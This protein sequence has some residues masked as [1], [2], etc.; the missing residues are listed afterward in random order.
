MIQLQLLFCFIV[1]REQLT[2]K[3]NGGLTQI[4]LIVTWCIYYEKI[5]YYELVTGMEKDIHASHKG[6]GAATN[7]E[8]GQG[9]TRTRAGAATIVQLMF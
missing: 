7:R 9:V 6:Q 8:K 1:S 2:C 5:Y 3:K 4:T